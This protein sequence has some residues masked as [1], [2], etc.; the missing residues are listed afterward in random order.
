MILCVNESRSCSFIHVFI[1]IIIINLKKY[2][3]EKEII[4]YYIPF[5]KK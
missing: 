5:Q 1:I 4:E 3:N 2:I